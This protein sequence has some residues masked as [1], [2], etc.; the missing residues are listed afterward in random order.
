MFA[1]YLLADTQESSVPPGQYTTKAQSTSG[2]TFQDMSS[3]LPNT[4]TSPI[5]I[6]ISQYPTALSIADLITAYLAACVEYVGICRIYRLGRIDST[7]RKEERL[8][9]Y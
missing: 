5:P 6:Y 3:V 8:D 9:I 1:S 2:T 4:C 7:T